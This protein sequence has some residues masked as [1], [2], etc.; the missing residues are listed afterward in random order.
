M[1]NK[2]II[3][4]VTGSIAA[5]KACDIIRQLKEK[6]FSVEVIMTKDAEEFITPLTLQTLSGNKVHRNMFDLASE[7]YNVEHISLADKADAVLV[8]PA[9]ANIIGK[10]ASGICDDLLTCV[11]MATK[12]KVI[13][14]PAM[15]D[16]MYS[17]KILQDNITRLKGSGYKFIGPIKGRL[18]NGKIGVGHLAEVDTIVQELAKLLK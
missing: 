3:L 9:T 2:N 16:G 11:I 13:F 12:A 17:N 6:G 14:A 4:G 18:A 8:A 15:N 7:E 1:K 10:V 5:Y